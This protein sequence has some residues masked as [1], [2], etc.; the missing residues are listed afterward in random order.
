MLTSRNS[1]APLRALLARLN[2]DLIASN[3][4][5]SNLTLVR[6]RDHRAAAS[7]SS[8]PGPRPERRAMA[9]TRA[10]PSGPGRRVCVANLHASAGPALRAAAEREV[11][12]G[13]GA[14]RR[15]GG[16]RRR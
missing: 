11:L 16:R 1:L 12:A 5:G 13:R 4:G 8:P 15:V 14:R 3:E 2:P 9:F 7:S 6:G 10:G